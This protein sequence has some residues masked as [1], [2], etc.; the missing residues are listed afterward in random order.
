[1]SQQRITLLGASGFLGSAIAERLDEL[2][3]DWRGVCISASDHPKILTLAPDDQ[4]SLIELINQYP[5]V[6]NATGSLKPKD[7]EARTTESLDLLW[8]NIQHFSSV[9][10]QSRI[11]K[12]VHLSSA[13]TVY[14]ESE[15]K[16]P[17]HE[18]DLLKPISWY[19]KAKMLE[20]LYYQ[21]MATK[22]NYQYLGLRV[23]NP[24]GNKLKTRHGFIDV[25]LN[26]VREGHEFNYYSDCDPV[27]DFIYAPDMAKAIVNLIAHQ[28]VGTFNI[29]S[30]QAIH[31]SDIASYVKKRVATPERIQ[32]TLARPSY[33]VLNSVV[34]IEKINSKGFLQTSKNVYD[35]IDSQLSAI[36]KNTD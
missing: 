17:H 6:I 10:E 20:E 21:D 33:D 1:M 15:D 24:F 29:G 36:D 5:V 28:E 2:N 7:F 3:L 4:D 13:G 34:S 18:E 32:R 22:H 14:G 8:R 9:L 23:T 25:L 31:L 26:C 27:R 19:G 35:Y 30:G 12:L 11:E 16:H